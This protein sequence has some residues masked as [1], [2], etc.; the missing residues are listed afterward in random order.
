MSHCAEAKIIY[1]VANDKNDDAS[2]NIFEGLYIN[3][4]IE[5]QSELIKEREQHSF[6]RENVL[7]NYHLMNGKNYTKI[8]I[9]AHEIILPELKGDRQV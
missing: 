6:V 7:L 1:C 8:K 2:A 9:K 3:M 4:L 5:L